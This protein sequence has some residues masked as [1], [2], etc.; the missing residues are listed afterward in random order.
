MNEAE[1][2]DDG[3]L[4]GK[5]AGPFSVGMLVDDKYEI[6]A[7]LGAGGMGSVYRAHHAELDHDVAIKVLH[8]RF[9]A[10]SD[11]VQRFQREARTIAQ[12]R[13]KNILSVYCFG[14]VNGLSYMA[15]EYVEGQSLAKVIALNGWLKPDQALPILGQICEA[16]TY[17]H[18]CG[19]LHRDL[20]PDNVV[21]IDTADDCCQIKVVDFGLAKLLDGDD[22]QKLT[23][24]GE[25]VGDPN[26][27]SPEQCQ[28]RPLDERS[29]IYS[30]GCLMYD[31]FSGDQPFRSETPVATLFKQ[32]SDDPEPFAQRLQVPPALEAITLTAMA[33]D[34]ADRY[35]SFASLH[36]ALNE[37]AANPNLKVKAPLRRKRITQRSRTNLIWASALALAVVSILVTSWLS[38]YN[39]RKTE[40][41]QKKFAREE[42][43]RILQ[44]ELRD[45]TG[46]MSIDDAKQLIAAADEVGNRAAMAQARAFLADSYYADGQL[47][48][49]YTLANEALNMP[50]LSY[51]PKPQLRNLA[52][53]TAFALRK[54]PEAEYHYQLIYNSNRVVRY[55]ATGQGTVAHNLAEIKLRLGK[56]DQCEEMLK[57]LDLS[58]MGKEKQIN[59]NKLLEIDLR[60]KKK[61]LAKVAALEQEMLA[62]PLQPMQKAN[63][64]VVLCIGYANAGDLPRARRTL[65][66][67]RKLI[68]NGEVKKQRLRDQATV[69]QLYIDRINLPSETTLQSASAL[70]ADL[71]RH[72]D[73]LWAIRQASDIYVETLGRLDRHAD[74][75]GIQS[76]TNVLIGKH[77]HKS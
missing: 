23:Q 54:L 62:T 72:S 45:Q 37:F 53:F 28:G 47:E 18:G 65:A 20:K 57:S 77:M 55:Q 44:R 69:L 16:M 60:F 6:T 68:G 15:M 67:L 58:W 8:P 61:Q 73:D 33:K 21:V 14:S 42:K 26:Y 17:A 9:A 2:R 75:K 51:I 63:A 74:I 46:A 48:N 76:R 50:E 31:I 29:D 5:A 52:A 32:V 19:V 4:A 7:Y 71:E 10:D 30:F 3:T 56:L 1:I 41:E 11:A 35:D 24:T 40:T 36:A 70:F 39:A 22:V 12:L 43:L 59:P 25:V 66:A 64:F 49:A 13:H 27:M 34:A 38:D